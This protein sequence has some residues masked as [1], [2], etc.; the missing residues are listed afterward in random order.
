[1]DGLDFFMSKYAKSLD[2]YQC[3][4]IKTS[5]DLSI[6]LLERLAFLGLYALISQKRLTLAP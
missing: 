5:F 6:I 4:T 1:M 3:I 2:S